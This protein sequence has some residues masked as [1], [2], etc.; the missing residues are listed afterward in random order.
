MYRIQIIV[1]DEGN[2]PI[3]EKKTWF[4]LK[5]FRFKFQSYKPYRAIFCFACSRI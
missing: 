1:F 3:S 4:H 2:G 5:T